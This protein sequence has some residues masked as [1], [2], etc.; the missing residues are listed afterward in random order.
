M[1]LYKSFCRSPKTFYGVTFNYGDSKAVPGYINDRRFVCLDSH[2]TEPEGHLKAKVSTVVVKEVP[3]VKSKSA[4]LEDSKSEK[5]ELK[6]AKKQ[7]ESKKAEV[8]KEDKPVAKK[9]EEKKSEIKDKVEKAK[10]AEKKSEVK[11]EEKKS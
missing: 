7:L 10:T 11:K 3:K 6:K 9:S 1:V 5:S 2:Y 4:T 8:K